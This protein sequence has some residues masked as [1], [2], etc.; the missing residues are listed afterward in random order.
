MSAIE[1]FINIHRSIVDFTQARA[2]ARVFAGRT[3]LARAIVLHYIDHANDS[4]FPFFF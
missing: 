2:D 4:D 1:V 3:R